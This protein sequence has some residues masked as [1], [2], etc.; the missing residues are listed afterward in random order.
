M[1]ARD[2]WL[3]KFT[4]VTPEPVTHD[5]IAEGLI[6]NACVGWAEANG[7]SVGGGVR[8][9][10]DRFGENSDNWIARF[11]FHQAQGE[12]LTAEHDA[13]RLWDV[14]VRWCTEHGY[15]LSGGFGSSPPE[16]CEGI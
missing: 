11:G 6:W 5:A 13:A 3:F 12:S 8:P 10:V 4:V 9:A 7:F 15:Q 14:I 2:E 1:S 16:E